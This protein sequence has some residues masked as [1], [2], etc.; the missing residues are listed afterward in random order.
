M[1]LFQ[2][3][4]K[5]IIAIDDIQ[6]QDRPCDTTYVQIHDWSNILATVPTGDAIYAGPLYT[7]EGYAFQLKVR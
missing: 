6:V 3:V 5:D 7:D 1:C 4:T 2:V